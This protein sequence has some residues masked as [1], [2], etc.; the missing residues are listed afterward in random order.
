M[1]KQRKKAKP[2][3]KRH[4]I[5]RKQIKRRSLIRKIKYITVLIVLLIIIIFAIILYSYYTEQERNGGNGNHSDINGN[6]I[7]IEVGQIAPDF[8]LTDT[9][10]NKFVLEDLHGSVVILD[11]LATWCGPCEGELEHLKEV[12]SQYDYTSVRIISIDVDNSESSEQLKNFK[13]N[14]S[15]DW[16]FAAGGGN[17]ADT[18][19]IESIPTIYVIDKQ[20]KI[21]YKNVGLTDYSILQSEIEK[22]L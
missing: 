8:E 3:R 9:D 6:N 5:K 1:I 10:N 20:G 19:G 7:G 21:T 13:Y 2:L 18:Y 11:F 4:E 15:C 14:H 17:V 12:R 16:I 22:L